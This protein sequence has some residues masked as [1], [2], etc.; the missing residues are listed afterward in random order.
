MVNTIAVELPEAAASA[1]AAASSATL[2]AIAARGLIRP[3]ATGRLRFSGWLRSCSASST[4]LKAYTAE[5]ARLNPSRP[6]AKGSTLKWPPAANEKGTGMNT[7][8]FLAQCLG[9]HNRR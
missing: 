9:R 8:A 5:L 2:D 6:S 3:A 1:I 4:S 7:N